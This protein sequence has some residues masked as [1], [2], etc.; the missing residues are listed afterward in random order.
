VEGRTFNT[1][2]LAGLVG[3]GAMGW[4]GLLADARYDTARNRQEGLA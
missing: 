4:D 1:M 2:A 3:R